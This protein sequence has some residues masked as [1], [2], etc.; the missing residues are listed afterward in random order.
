MPADKHKYFIFIFLLDVEEEKKP[1]NQ[2]K[3]IW[4]VGAT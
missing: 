2:C 4:E 1:K 3:L